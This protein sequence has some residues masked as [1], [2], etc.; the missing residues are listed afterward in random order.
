[1]PTAAAAAKLTG[2]STPA[3]AYRLPGISPKAYEHPADRAATAALGS[4]PMLD[5]V[6]RKLIEFG[7][8]RALRQT[9]LG[10]SVRLGTDQL[11]AIW[12]RY[13]HVLSVLDMPEEY[14]L[15]LTAEPIANAMAIGAGKPILVLNS[16]TVELLDVEQL[17]AV[18]AH[19]VG[20]ILS[21]HVLYRTA[22]QIL[23]RLGS[24]RLPMVAGMPLLAV[25]HALLEWSRAT[26]LTCD[27]AAAI[28]TR[29]PRVVC[30]MLMTMSGGAKADDLNLD[31][32]MRQAMEYTESGEGLDR[33]Q[34]LLTDL[35]QTHS[36]PVKRVHEL[37]AWVRDGEYDRIVGGEYTRRGQERPAREEAADAATHYS[38]RFKDLFRETGEHVNTAGK[39]LSDWLK[40]YGDEDKPPA[41]RPGPPPS[42]GSHAGR[43][44]RPGLPHREA[45]HDAGRVS[46]D[47]QRAARGVQP[48]DEPRSRRR[49]RRDDDPRRGHAPA[50][51]PLGAPVQRRRQPHGEVPP[52]AR[53]GADARA[54]RARRALRAHAARRAD[55]GRAEGALRAPASV[56]RPR[57]HPHHARAPH[58]ARPRRAAP[59]PAGSEGGALCAP[60][61]RRRRARTAARRWP[62]RHRSRCPDPSSA[63]SGRP[64]PSAPEVQRVELPLS[65]R[66]A[67]LEAE[68]T[69]LRAELRALRGR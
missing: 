34:R 46:A 23:L 35:R 6:V 4:I 8:E 14:D 2:V 53:R 40:K 58:R 62:G 44:A 39:Q 50:P 30:K 49:L 47:A 57:R 60:P 36:L 38:E 33:L 67:R 52:P 10:A 63:R 64:M 20:H 68:V 28:V 29:D 22:L 15:Y 27:R 17:E 3:E 7:Y 32:F 26:E 42:S 48:V 45:A 55:A 18:I 9:Y 1:M 5:Y 31:A 24:Q 19:E 61:V 51:P 65:E 16:A 69:Q 54:R 37:L 66:V 13:Q 12:T 59:A 25:Q 11:P 41:A 21:D 43:A 56:R